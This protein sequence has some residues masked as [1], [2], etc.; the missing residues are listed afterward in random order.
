M[1]L[2]EIQK[3]A[4]VPRDHFMPANREVDFL[5][6]SATPDT[7]PRR[8]AEYRSRDRAAPMLVEATVH[9]W[10]TDERRG[11]CS[12]NQFGLMPTTPVRFRCV[13]AISAK[14]PKRYRIQ[15]AQALDWLPELTP[16]ELKD[17]GVSLMAAIATKLGVD[18]A[19]VSCDVLDMD[20]TD[21]VGP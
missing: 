9:W 13:G 17:L 8:R 3:S 19:P 5:L 11:T 2:K 7:R 15:L 1:S 21:A 4:A 18:V 16:R 10:R 6:D 14:Y 20:S 12:S